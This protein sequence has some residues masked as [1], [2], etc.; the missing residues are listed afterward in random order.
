MAN[1]VMVVHKMIG[2]TGLI[3]SIWILGNVC[4][5]YTFKYGL[6]SCGVD[7][8]LGQVHT[9]KHD[10]LSSPLTSLKESVSWATKEYCD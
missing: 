6:S 8:G 7:G 1:I 10:H 9:S 2:N 4:S 3:Q 5:F